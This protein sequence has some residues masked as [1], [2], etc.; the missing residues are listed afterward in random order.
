MNLKIITLIWILFAW[1][2][3]SAQENRGNQLRAGRATDN[4]RIDGNLSENEWLLAD[5]ISRFTAIE[6]EE[7]SNPSFPTTVKVLFS[8][9]NIYIVHVPAE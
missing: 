2:P 4:I 3:V 1:L 9:K 7:G 6:P 5:S 8:Q